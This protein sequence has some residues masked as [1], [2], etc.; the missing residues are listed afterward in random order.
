MALVTGAS[1]GI[2]WVVCQTLAAAGMRVVAVARRRD[3]LEALQQ[4]LVSSGIAITDFLPIVCD[5]SKVRA[6]CG[7]LGCHPPLPERC[8]RWTFEWLPGCSQH[9]GPAWACTNC[10]VHVPHCPNECKG[11]LAAVS[12]CSGQILS[13]ARTQQC[14]GHSAGCRRHL[15]C[16]RTL[17]HR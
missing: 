2:G 13:P 1:A 16:L 10:C 15:D 4:D 8:A 11:R 12:S 6:V 14:W 7:Q 5:I 3:R 17:H 9:C